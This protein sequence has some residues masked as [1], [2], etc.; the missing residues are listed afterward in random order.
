STHIITHQKTDLSHLVSRQ[1]IIVYENTA[2]IRVTENTKSE[3]TTQDAAYIIYTSGSTGHPKGVLISHQSVIQLIQSLQKT[4][5]LQEQQVHLQFASFIFDASVWEIYGSLLTGGR[6]HLV[7]EIERKSIDHFLAVIQA[8]NVQY[9]LVPTVF[10]HTLTQATSQQLKQLLSLRYIFV[11]GE[12][13]LP[14]MVRNWQA[15]VGLNI[16]VVN[17]YG[18]T[19][20][21]VCATTYPVTQLLHKEQTYIPIGKPLPHI[22]MY[23]LNEQGK[24]C[25]PYVP[26]EINIGGSS[27]AAAYI[28]QPEKTKETFLQRQIPNTPEMKVYKSG[29]QGRI[30]YDGHIEF[31]GRQDKQIKIRGYRIEL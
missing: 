2:K 11:G 12:T 10:F 22:K 19:E 30:T 7:A 18:P 28:N 1:S 15:K 6:L 23:V 5:G 21:T 13:L 16:P 3:H 14:A 17:A 29:D 8:Q 25:P 24:L 4:Y 26:G 20:I 31:L 27:L 9:C